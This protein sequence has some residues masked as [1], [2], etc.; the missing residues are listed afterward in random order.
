MSASSES[1]VI[2][3]LIYA[4][5]MVK[6]GLVSHLD[7]TCHLTHKLSLRFYSSGLVAGVPPTSIIRGISECPS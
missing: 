4:M 2:Q 7:L 3:A 1:S 5:V 6:L